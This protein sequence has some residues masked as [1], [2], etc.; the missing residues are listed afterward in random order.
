MAMDVMRPVDA[1]ATAPT[2]RLD[3]PARWLR[4]MLLVLVTTALAILLGAATTPDSSRPA[5][6]GHWERPS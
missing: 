2:S 1:F 5:T 3:D 4:P 6:A